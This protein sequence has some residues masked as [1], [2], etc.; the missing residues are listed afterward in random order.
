MFICR[1]HLAVLFFTCDKPLR[2]MQHGSQIESVS[3]DIPTV[4]LDASEE[5]KCIL[6]LSNGKKT[7]RDQTQWDLMT[8][9][10]KQ[11]DKY[12]Q[13]KI[14]LR[15]RQCLKFAEDDQMNWCKAAK[16]TADT[17]EASRC[18]IFFF[19]GAVHL[20]GSTLLDLG[21]KKRRKELKK[22]RKTLNG[23]WVSLSP[24]A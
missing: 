21:R 18:P 11:T 20:F 3:A 7:R 8:K 24:V 2:K 6:V 13:W 16:L 17:H 19:N 23:S 5:L 9:R 12:Y 15:F 10:S 22:R 1:I 14:L 4:T